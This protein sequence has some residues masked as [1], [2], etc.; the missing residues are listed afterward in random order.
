MKIKL[1]SRL[2][3]LST[4]LRIGRKCFRILVSVA[5]VVV[6]LSVAGVLVHQELG[7]SVVPLIEVEHL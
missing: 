7:V 4:I 1:N 5:G 2:Q 3:E 6:H